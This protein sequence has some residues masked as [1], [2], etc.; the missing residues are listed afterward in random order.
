MADAGSDANLSSDEVEY[1]GVGLGSITLSAEGVTVFW[2][3]GGCT[4]A[5]G[6][7]ADSSKRFTEVETDRVFEEVNLR[8]G[9]TWVYLILMR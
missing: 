5:E 6:F 8:I 7:D 3:L 1:L 9:A 2:G 4:F